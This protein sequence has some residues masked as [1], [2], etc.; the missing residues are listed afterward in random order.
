M[1]EDNPEI[2]HIL[3]TSS[4]IA[5]DF[6][7]EYVTSEHV[8][9][10]LIMHKPFH[11]CLLDY[12]TDLVNFITELD[13]YLQSRDDI[14]VPEDVDPDYR[15]L[16]TTGV[17]RIFHRAFTQIMFRNQK[18]MTTLDLFISIAQEEGSM[19]S[20]FIQKYGIEPETFVK[21]Y[22][23][24]YLL[25]AAKT[26]NM[27]EH[28][29]SKVLTQY[30][31]DLN[32]QVKEGK[33][34]P[35]IGREY[36][37]DKIA[38]VLAK[39]Q[40]CNVLMV[41]DPGVGKTAIA[42][43]LA[44]KIEENDVPDYIKGWNVFNLDIGQLL[45]GSKYR[46]D[47]EEKFKEVMDALHSH[48][49]AILF[50]DEAHQMRGA[51]GGGSQGGV[52]F[53]NMIKPAIAKGN[54]KVIASTTW[55]EY[56][57]SFEK[58]R[59]L[60]RRFYRLTIDEPTPAVSKDILRGLKVHYDEFH[61]ANIQDE[62][63]VAAVDLSVRY[64]TDKR[65]PDKA[66]DLVDTACAYKRLKGEVD[67]KITK[68]DI[69][70]EI[71]KLTKIPMDQLDGEKKS[72]TVLN[73]DVNIKSK[74]FGQEDAVDK[75][76]EKVYVAKAGL[77]P[78]NKPMGS[79]LL[80]GPTGTGKT[81]LARLLAQNL[82]MKFADFSMTE[83]MEKHTVSRLIG[84]PPGYVGFDDGN[85]GGGALIKVLEQSPNC[86][87]LFDEIEKAHPDVVNILL[88]LM[89]E[90][91]VTG[92]NGKRA[93]GRNALILLTS[94]LGA[95]ESEVRAIGFGGTGVRTDEDTKAV[96]EFFKPEFRN[97]LD[98]IVKFNKLG[99]MAMRKIVAK[100]LVEVSDRL[101]DKE[102]TL[103]VSEP[104]IDHLLEVGFDAKFGAR[105]LE[106]TINKLI[107]VPL[108]K[109]ILFEAVEVGSVVDVQYTDDKVVF[110]ISVQKELQYD[111]VE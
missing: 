42:E 25:D 77:K 90:G 66:I 103:H 75:L 82:H 109:K 79:F 13:T 71:S 28:F 22:N 3:E 34:D 23:E 19:S 27:P 78:V 24:N 99:K 84:S 43:G 61:K 81:E 86:V 26:G 57:Q 55:E 18:L 16:R 45:A 108:S 89:D 100:F 67:F 56:T 20:Y 91:F 6:A 73:L 110:D 111:H 38:Q 10:A 44:R 92:S 63:I 68:L 87:L 105:P 64:Q 54:I 12:G 96:K 9:Y 69:A 30:C 21:H 35:V 5:K 41:G 37:L 80:I 7:H 11:A 94:N 51:G 106:R 52:D 39:R 32:A 47:F 74:L 36:E 76:L 15:P 88:Q 93:D 104:M 31:T 50:I 72:D 48:G 46:G 83:F 14:S 33:I 60:M 1:F 40:K 107:T 62:A 70:R 59:A 58:D 65:L 53:A 97:R 2:T 49:N 85:V 29:V 4:E 95:Q 17:A 98:G 8:L 101:Q 102:I